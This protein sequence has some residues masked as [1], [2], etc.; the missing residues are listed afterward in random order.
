MEI[1]Y[2]L[3]TNEQVPKE[4]VQ[5]FQVPEPI[6]P[7]EDTNKPKYYKP[8]YMPPLDPEFIKSIIPP[9]QPPPPPYYPYS[10]SHN[11]P[12]RP[13]YPPQDYAYN[14]Y[15][16]TFA[17]PRTYSP[18]YIEPPKYVPDSS[19]LHPQENPIPAHD[20][21]KDEIEDKFEV[22]WCGFL[23]RSKVHRLG[24]DA[25]L[26]SGEAKKYL[27]D[28]GLNISHKTSLEEAAKA[29]PA[30]VGVIAFVAQ[31]VTQNPMFDNYLE[32]FGSKGK[33]SVDV[34]EVGWFN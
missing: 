24:V 17:P 28:H 15:P 12:P 27:I 2:L 31:D 13:S 22:V 25:H 33:V 7:Y 20:S 4:I 1:E 30:V 18:P 34:R 21:R 9:Y 8:T 29:S 10:C 5:K 16:Q 3:Y 6:R 11:I 14:P 23:T 19:T 26:I 32:Y